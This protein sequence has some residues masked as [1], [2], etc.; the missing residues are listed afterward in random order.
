VVSTAIIAERQE[1][2]HTYPV[3]R[4]V[5]FV[6]EVLSESKAHYQSSTEPLNQLEMRVLSHLCKAWEANQSNHLRKAWEINRISRLYKALEVV[7]F[8]S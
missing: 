3:Q 2:G 5:Y 1:N 6:R 4:P 8:N 7:Q